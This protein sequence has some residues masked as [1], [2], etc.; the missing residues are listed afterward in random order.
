[1]E[2]AHF[3]WKASWLYTYGF[4]YYLYG[5][6]LLSSSVRWKEV[7]ITMRYPQ[8]GKRYTNRY[9]DGSDEGQNSVK[10]DPAT[11]KRSTFGTKLV[12][13]HVHTALREYLGLEN[14]TLV[15]SFP[16]ND[17]QRFNFF[18]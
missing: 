4:E 1:M 14:K 2:R 10:I 16:F 11:L 18:S 13:S 17:D 7:P 9:V 15:S 12:T 3:D 5:K 8:K 6:V